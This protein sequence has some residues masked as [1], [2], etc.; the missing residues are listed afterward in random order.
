MK[1]IPSLVLAAALVPAA[2]FCAE[3]KLS[4]LDLSGMQQGWQKPQIDRSVEGHNL[5]IGP[6]T[7]GH[8]IGTHAESSWT[9]LL[10][11]KAERFHAWVGIDGEVG[12]KGSAEFKV[13]TDGKEAW[14]SGVLKGKGEAKEAT[15]PLPGVKRLDLIVL[16]GQGG[17]DFDHAD[18]AEAVI[19]TA[20]AAPKPLAAVPEEAVV[21]TPKPGPAPRL[22]G[23]RVFGARPGSPFLHRLT[24]TGTK[25]MTFSAEGLP[26]GVS[27][28][29][30]T[31]RLSG[32]LAGQ[33]EWKVKVTAKNAVGK[34]EGTL[35]VVGG[36][37]IALT[38]PMGWNSWNCFA[39]A[40]TDKHIRDAA[41]TMAESGLADHGW[42][43]INIDD[44]WQVQPN[45]GD[46][47]L[48]GPPRGPDGR[49][50]PNP[51]FPDMKALTDY[52]H[53]LGFKIGLYSSPG[54]LTCGGCIGSY[55][56]EKLDAATYAEWGF[57][58]LKHDWCS[59]NPKLEKERPEPLSYASNDPRFLGLNESKNQRQYMIPY[60]AMQDALRS[61]KRDIVYSLCQ[62][63]MGDVWEWGARVDGN[64]W[65]TTGDINDS[66]S[67]MSGIGFGQAGH[68]RFSG[69]GHWNDPDML[70][71]GYVG[72]GPALHP[73]KLTPNEQYTHISLWS[74]L[75][76]PLLIGCDLTK[77]DDFTT[78]LLTNDEV[79]E[80][81]Q[82]PLGKQAARV[83]K[84][85][86]FEVWAKT[87]EDGSTACGLFNR[88]VMEKKVEVKLSDIGVAKAA[89]LRDVWTQKDLPAPGETIAG[90]LPRHGCRLFRI[91]PTK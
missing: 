90:A 29:A 56:H 77:L 86:D 78:G 38:P 67:S 33:G 9:L 74:L 66:W 48:Q 58:Y 70:V 25:P 80:I 26:P 8:G 75:C 59:Y 84:D 3:I 47:T 61:Q 13:L 15:V 49:I 65:R 22:T 30:S 46:K 2:A 12:E 31:G 50:L 81:N 39:S 45:S 5:T 40:V 34:A 24:A 4:T 88:G 41:R 11:G 60:L 52:V 83:F 37:T 54:P 64:C 14:S 10:D 27:L 85:G 1:P 16:E 62:Y 72:W 6:R 53:G 7:F 73:T 87:M 23:A 19:V 91:W 21:L 89:R 79:I 20:G 42:T 69:P 36:D 32:A 51:R 76:S 55:A 71:V 44:F 18:W 35:R 28:D 63:G 43:Y 17:I 57:D 82:D 68:E